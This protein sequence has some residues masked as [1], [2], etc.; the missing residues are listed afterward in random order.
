MLNVNRLRVL[1]EVAQRGS[2]SAAAQELSYTQSA[3]SQQIAA[4]EEEVGMTLLERRPRGVR[5]TPAGRMLVAHAEGILAR[6]EAAETELVG[7]RGTARG[8]AADGHLSHRG[9]H[10]DAGGDRRLPCAPSAGG[11]DADRGRARG[12]RAADTRR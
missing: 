3:V 7:D 12:D 9:R 2:F 5:A 1:K 6:L 11:A 10:V 4:L 8:T